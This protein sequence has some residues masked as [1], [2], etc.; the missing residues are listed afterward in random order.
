MRLQRRE[1][2]GANS[3]GFLNPWKPNTSGKFA[4]WKTGIGN[5]GTLLSD[6]SQQ[7]STYH[8]N[9]FRMLNDER[10]SSIVQNGT[11]R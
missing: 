3:R 2:Q 6:F 5:S 7:P 10:I 9:L 8:A 1:A 4:V 11:P